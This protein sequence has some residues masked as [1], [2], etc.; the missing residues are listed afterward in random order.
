MGYEQGNTWSQWLV[1]D[2]REASG[3]PDVV[4]FLSDTLTEPMKISGEPIANLVAS[5][6]GTDADWVVKLIDVYPDEVAGDAV[7]G[8]YQLMIAA[9]IFRGRYRENF[10]DGQDDHT[11]YAAAVP[12]CSPDGKPRFSAGTS[13]HGADPVELVPTIRP[14]SA[15]I[16]PQYLLGETDGLPESDATGLPRT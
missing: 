8:G 1:D 10:D 13:D 4:A 7:M 2:Q 9:D 15:D 5:T 14:Q 3:R 16:R 11:G 12:L 6:S